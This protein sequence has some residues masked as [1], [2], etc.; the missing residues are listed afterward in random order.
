MITAKL[1]LKIMGKKYY[2][3][4]NLC[5]LS[6]FNYVIYAS[7]SK[8]RNSENFISFGLKIVNWKGK[9][10]YQYHYTGDNLEMKF[11]DQIQMFMEEN[12][13]KRM[14]KESKL[15]NHDYEFF[16]FE[17]SCLVCKKRFVAK[18]DKVCHFTPSGLY[19]GDVHSDCKFHY[20]IFPDVPVIL[21]GCKLE[22]IA[23]MFEMNK[24]PHVYEIFFD[25]KYKPRSERSFSLVFKESEQ[26]IP[27]L[28]N[29]VNDFLPESDYF[30]GISNKIV[31]KIVSHSLP[32]NKFIDSSDL[33]SHPIYL[34]ENDKIFFQL[35]SSVYCSTLREY[36]N[37]YISFLTD[38]FVL[39]F[40]TFR[41][42]LFNQHHLD[43]IHYNT[44]SHFSFDALLLSIYFTNFRP[45]IIEEQTINDF[46]K[47]GIENLF[48][49]IETQQNFVCDKKKYIVEFNLCHAFN[50]A[51]NQCIPIGNFS[52]VENISLEKI[53]SYPDAGNVGFILEIDLEHKPNHSRIDQ[54]P[55]SPFKLKRKKNL[56][57]HFRLLK[58]LVETNWDVVKIHKI[59][60]FDQS[61]W[62]NGYSST[63]TIISE[64]SIST[65]TRSI[66]SF[67]NSS[68]FDQTLRNL[69]NKDFVDK[70]FI[71]G[72][73]DQK[74]N[75][76]H[77]MYAKFTLLNLVR[78]LM[79]SF[80]DNISKIETDIHIISSQYNLLRIGIPVNHV[81]KDFLNKIRLNKNWS[82]YMDPF[83]ENNFFIASYQSY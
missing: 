28:L 11:V 69:Y 1:I 35:F 56:I 20:T 79:Y 40:E 33:D 17:K 2:E 53:L 44:I 60:K 46:F 37:M 5:N 9:C 4:K 6:K 67:V 54:F 25:T 29:R 68:I 64:N 73:N 45:E 51:M 13:I 8:F 70:P 14:F 24:K 15:E 38:L 63:N 3:F 39:I 42:E 34:K 81:Y 59:L 23:R 16:C 66:F 27:N 57:L 41:W 75:V 26:F 74:I 82:N 71:N 31:R 36:I 61:T 47:Q 7:F 80:F 78:F 19:V 72:W 30:K 48:E 21:Y 58:L 43:P 62:M 65:S 83:T 10:V 32:D 18:N 12:I 49:N 50:W 76:H 55:E 22:E 77:P 52:W